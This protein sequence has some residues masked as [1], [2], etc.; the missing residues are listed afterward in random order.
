MTKFEFKVD[1]V[2]HVLHTIQTLKEY[3]EKQPSL[4]NLH[5]TQENLCLCK[6]F[7]ID[8]L[9]QYNIKF[10]GLCNIL[11]AIFRGGS[12]EGL[13]NRDKII[14]CIQISKDRVS[15][16]RAGRDLSSSIRGDKKAPFLGGN[17]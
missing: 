6:Y 5:S 17:V 4:M 12:Q 7:C 9:F 3:W 11:W 15:T 2:V 10:I 14:N 16:L 1:G 8:N 13:Q